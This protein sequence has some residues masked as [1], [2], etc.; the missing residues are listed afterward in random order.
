MISER[1][2]PRH[3]PGVDLSLQRNGSQNGELPTTPLSLSVRD[4]NKINSLPEMQAVELTKSLSPKTVLKSSRVSSVSP[5][6]K[7]PVS[8]GSSTSPNLYE[9][10]DSPKTIKRST[11]RMDSIIERLNPI[12]PEQ[13]DKPC[14]SSVIVQP[15]S[16]SGSIDENSNSG[17]V[18]N[19]PTST[20]TRDEDVISPYSNEDST[21][22]NKSRRKR[23]PAKTMRVSKEVEKTV[24]REKHNVVDSSDNANAN[25]EV[26]EVQQERRRSGSAPPG[27]PTLPPKTRRKTS[28]ESETIANIA[29]MVKEQINPQTNCLSETENNAISVIKT[30][31]NLDTK[32]DEPAA[33]TNVQTTLQQVKPTE[34]NSFVEVENKLEEMFA[35]I[36]D[37]ED[38]AEPIKSI[39]LEYNDVNK[40]LGLE[41]HKNEELTKSEAS[42]SQ[43]NDSVTSTSNDNSETPKRS[44]STTSKSQRS[45]DSSEV[46][47]KRKKGIF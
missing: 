45:N 37:D 34:S 41:E 47:P 40:T 31:E 43:I 2:Y 4:A 27:S 36:A 9:K 10:Q 16:I 44:K 32:A 30:N 23:K 20:S 46:S 24:E 22:S 7:G 35:G 28:S 11:K 1:P 15:A 42:T 29:A 25:D 5:T 18:L 38:Q 26:K 21:D 17:S 33:V 8:P 3:S 19:A 13:S 6:V 39:P 12:I 14:Q